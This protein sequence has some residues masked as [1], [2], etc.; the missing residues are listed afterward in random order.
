[1]TWN[2]TERTNKSIPAADARPLQ[3]LEV[4]TYHD[5]PLSDVCMSLSDDDTNWPQNTF[6]L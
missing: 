4:L 6:V 1:M 2:R 5:G 3:I